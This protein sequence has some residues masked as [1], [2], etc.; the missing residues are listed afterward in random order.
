MKTLPRARNENILVQE[1]G[2]EVMI[3]DS[4][5]DKAY[6]L[7]KT[8]AVIFN[9][10]DGETTFDELQRRFNY[11]ED[12]IYLALDE[13]KRSNLLNDKEYVS[14]LNGLSRREAVKK[15]GLATMLALPVIT[16]LTAPTAVNAA[17]SSCPAGS[18]P[19][20]AFGVNGRND[21]CLCPPGT[22]LGAT[23]NRGDFAFGPAFSCRTGCLC[24][25]TGVQANGPRSG[26]CG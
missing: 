2:D 5:A 23:C 25:T 18:D 1:I 16:A 19:A 13:L 24:I 20:D 12:L 22:A 15:V 17:S 21:T 3:Y 9:N 6:C 26:V 4:A 10:C 11:T 14:M 8:S 7:N